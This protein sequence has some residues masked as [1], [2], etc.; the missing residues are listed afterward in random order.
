M[1]FFYIIMYKSDIRII[2]EI[3]RLNNNKRSMD[4]INQ[5]KLVKQ[6]DPLRALFAAYAPKEKQADLYALTLLN[7]EISSIIDRA[8][9]PLQAT[10]RLQFWLLQ[11]EKIHQKEKPEMMEANILAQLVQDY[12]LDMALL[13]QWIL[14]RQKD[15]SHLPHDNMEG[16]AQYLRQ[17]AGNLMIFWDKIIRKSE[18]SDSHKT[19]LQHIGMLWGLVGVLRALRY[20]SSVRLCLLPKDFLYDHGLFIH[21]AWLPSPKDNIAP[22]IAKLAADARQ[23]LIEIK[24]QNLKDFDKSIRL[25]LTAVESLLAHMQRLE[26]DPFHPLWEI[27][28]KRMYWRILKTGLF[29]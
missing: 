23:Q 12:D 24:K 20:H 16:L 1:V 7:A 14:V 6:S 18:Q 5:Q 3:A 27:V 11:L 8:S 26:Y 19:L 9:E 17:S 22:I 25:H 13:Q 4:M 2:Y 10:A 15:Y 21:A 28:P 29:G